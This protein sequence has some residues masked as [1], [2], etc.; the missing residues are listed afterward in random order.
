MRTTEKYWPWWRWILVVLNTLAL[1]LSAIMSWH[2]LAG[3]PMIGCGGG[4][5]CEQVLSSQWS[6]IAGILPVSGLAVGVYLSMLVAGIFI[7][8]A[9]EVPIRR[10]AWSMMLVLAGSVAGSAIWFTIVQ[11][12]IIGDFCT[13]CMITH[14]T[15]MLLAVLII[16]RAVKYLTGQNIR[17]LAVL[18]RF[19][20]GLVLS[21]LLVISQVILTSGTVYI[22]GE[23][24]KSVTA[25][26]YNN[27]PVIGPPDATYVV[28]LLFDYQ[29]A[30][31]QKLHFMLDEA[32]N[33]Y[34]GKLAFA[35][36]P[37]P[38]NTQCNPYIPEDADQFRNSCELTKIGL[39]VWL[40]DREVFP[41]F[42]NWM[43][44]F[45]S[46]DR[47]L[48]RS[49]EATRA[50]AI[51]LVGQDK[52]NSLLEDPWIDTYLQTTTGIY[53]QTL[54]NGM[55]GIPKLVFGSRWVIP[56]PDSFEDLVVIMQ[57]SLFVPMP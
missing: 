53:G 12:W 26:D 48:P 13:F 21:G 8:P 42:E 30:H 2:Y 6:K 28:S 16:R 31:C 51:E 45:E 7:G 44:T 46:G 56:Q 38:L 40:A 5:P 11:K 50:K 34:S 4:S 24:D 3:G 37:S 14:I 35:L 15:G 55:G 52:F 1:V 32:V 49:P 54:Q 19:L 36:C 47:W 27:V 39:A 10:L 17:P 18:F 57:K 33:S 41:E 43:F 25:I 20:A 9:T 23:S 22:D 29:C